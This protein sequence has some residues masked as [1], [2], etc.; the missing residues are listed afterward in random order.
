MTVGFRIT[1]TPI[2]HGT[3][4]ELPVQWESGAATTY[5]GRGPVPMTLRP[6]PPLLCIDALGK[7]LYGV[8]TFNRTDLINSTTDLFETLA[9][10]ILEVR[11]VNSRPP[12]GG[13]H[14]RCPHRARHRQHGTHVDRRPPRNRPAICCASPSTSARFST[15]WSSCSGVRHFIARDEWTLRI[16]CDIAEWAG[17]L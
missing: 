11:G 8:E 3:Y 16:N 1:A 15:A 13:G 17:V 10:R 9:D 6:E 12:R 7:S 2:D 5:T 4:Y 14:D